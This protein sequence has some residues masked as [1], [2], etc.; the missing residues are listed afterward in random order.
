MSFETKKKCPTENNDLYKR[1]EISLYIW[2]TLTP[3]LK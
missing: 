1:L 2:G 3:L